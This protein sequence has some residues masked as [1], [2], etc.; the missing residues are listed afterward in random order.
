[1]NFE[2]DYIKQKDDY[3][4]LLTEIDDLKRENKELRDTVRGFNK[5][6]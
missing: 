5:E 2:Q 6:K 4:G 1:M 3:Q